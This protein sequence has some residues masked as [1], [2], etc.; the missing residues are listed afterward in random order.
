MLTFASIHEQLQTTQEGEIDYLAA[1]QRIVE[2]IR[3][4]YGAYGVEFS[5]HGAPLM[6]PARLAT[7]LA[8]V[9]NELIT[10]AAKHGCTDGKKCEV[11][12]R[13]GRERGSLWLSVWNSGT[14]LGREF[15]IA[16]DARLGLRLVKT[17]VEEQHAGR[18][19]LRPEEN[20][21]CAEVIVPET[22]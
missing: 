8:M 1:L 6:L 11:K 5:V 3:E 14:P 4:V 19:S 20:G 18:F 9:A 13:F 2:G 17:L 21:T 22:A 15:T 7:N 10:N 16:K 12:V